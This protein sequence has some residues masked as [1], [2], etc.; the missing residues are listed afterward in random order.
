MRSARKS[1]D[2]AEGPR[3]GMPAVDVAGAPRGWVLVPVAMGVPTTWRRHSLTLRKVRRKGA[4]ERMNA[5]KSQEPVR[6]LNFFQTI[7]PL[8][9]SHLSVHAAWCVRRVEQHH[10]LNFTPRNAASR[11]L[12]RSH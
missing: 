4:S 9:R 3:A 1:G 2:V 5:T 12:S 8:P 7:P 6:P 10:L 11:F